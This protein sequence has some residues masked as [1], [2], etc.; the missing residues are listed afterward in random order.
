M[1]FSRKEYWSGLPYLPPGDFPNQGTNLCLLHWQMGSLPSEPP[2]KSIEHCSK[3]TYQN[4]SLGAEWF[5]VWIVHPWDLATDRSISTTHLHKRGLHHILVAWE[6]IRIKNFKQFLLKVNHHFYTIIILK[7]PK[8]KHHNLGT[9]CM[10]EELVRSGVQE[11]D[12][13]DTKAKTG[14]PRWLSG[15]E[16]TLKCRRCQ[17]LWLYPWVRKIPWRRKWQPTPL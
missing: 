3:A 5:Q 15:K 4:H 6:K 14:L 2:G 1:G 12:Q 16:S 7:T 8:L 17:T 10:E 11:V 9:I 13:R